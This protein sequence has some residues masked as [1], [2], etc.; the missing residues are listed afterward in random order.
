MSTACTAMGLGSAVKEAIESQNLASMG[1]T[2]AGSVVPALAG[3]SMLVPAADWAQ[4]IEKSASS[5]A[6][7]GEGTEKGTEA[8]AKVPC[9]RK[10]AIFACVPGPL[11]FAQAF[12]KGGAAKKSA[13]A[14]E[15]NLSYARS[16]S[17]DSGSLRA[18]EVNG[19]A[20]NGPKGAGTGGTAGSDGD[21]TKSDGATASSDKDKD[22]KTSDSDACSKVGT[23]S[24]DSSSI[25]ECA[26][27]GNVGLDAGYLRSSQFKSDFENGTRMSLDSFLKQATASNSSPSKLMSGALA[28]A[29]GGKL[30][31]ATQAKVEKAY[32]D[33]T[34]K[35]AALPDGG[36]GSMYSRSTLL[37]DKSNPFKSLFGNS[38]GKMTFAPFSF[39]SK[40][41]NSAEQ[42]ASASEV[43]IR[44]TAEGNHFASDFLEFDLPKNWTCAEKNQTFE[45]AEDSP[46]K[47]RRA[48]IVIAAKIKNDRENLDN[49]KKRLSAPKSYKTPVTQKIVQ[50]KIEYVKNIDIHAHPWVDALH[51]NSEINGYYTRYLATLK[52][53]MAVLVTFSVA[54]K[55]YVQFIPALTKAVESLSVRNPNKIPAP[56]VAQKTPETSATLDPSLVPSTSPTALL[57]VEESDTP[58]RKP[59]STN[60]LTRDEITFLVLVGGALLLFIYVRRRKI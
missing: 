40:N 51:L 27:A 48:L 23:A 45:C 54:E 35:V 33:L 50:S 28:S 26:I 8:G 17:S 52:D 56:A 29:A 30:D 11:A 12:M 31:S 18:T 39:N 19:G 22:K 16:L 3:N 7:A 44:A 38:N 24:Q 1:A 59:A 43:A 32:D 34:Q 5:A 14:A 53:D 9:N 58:R 15:K 41:S 55:N 60:A 49:F 57:P 46:D 2:L 13:M 4:N 21:K 36:E 37:G 10:A 25:V 47:K 20:A 42:S 6:A